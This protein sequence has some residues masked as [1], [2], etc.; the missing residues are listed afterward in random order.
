ME[1]REG[2][3]VKEPG[4]ELILSLA[5]TLLL[6]SFT[7]C[8]LRAVEGDS[9]RGGWQCVT[10]SLAGAPATAGTC[11]HS[12]ATSFSCFS[13][14]ELFLGEE[15]HVALLFLGSLGLPRWPE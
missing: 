14:R 10:N 8:V 9:R 6:E 2:M 13:V 11:Q 4:S 7:R 3:S 12:L 15:E 5:L 1:E